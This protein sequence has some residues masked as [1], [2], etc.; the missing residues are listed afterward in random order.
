[1]FHSYI[2]PVRLS[3]CRMK[4]LFRRAQADGASLPREGPMYTRGPQVRPP[5]PKAGPCLPYPAYHTML[6]VC[7]DD[8]YYKREADWVGH[9]FRPHPWR[10]QELLPPMGPE[11]Y[12]AVYWG[13]D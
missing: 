11:A 4:K 7:T 2:L 12:K 10:Y 3:Y 9:K 5:D 13:Q 8:L 1:M 6:P